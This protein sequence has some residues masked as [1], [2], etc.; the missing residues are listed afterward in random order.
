MKILL[1]LA[2]FSLAFFSGCSSLSPVGAENKNS[3]CRA[4]HE[5]PPVDRVHEAHTVRQQYACSLCHPG[6]TRDAD[7]AIAPDAA[8]HANGLLNIAIAAPYDSSRTATYNP[9]SKTCSGVYCHG[10]FA[11]GT[12]AAITVADSVALLLDC[13]VCHD[14]DKMAVKGHHPHY[15][16]NASSA[17]AIGVPLKCEKCHDGFAY[18]PLASRIVNPLTHIDGKVGPINDHGCVICHAAPV[19][20][21]AAQTNCSF[22]HK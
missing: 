1:I 14:I 16:E 19:T 3:K 17:I 22:C 2:A 8:T 4:C 18:L 21:G 5:V 20:H 13:K 6:T 7:G 11:S 15:P 9:A 10:N 12:H